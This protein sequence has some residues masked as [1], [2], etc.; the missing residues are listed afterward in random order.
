MPLTRSPAAQT[1][2]AIDQAI[3]ERL[4]EI[5]PQY[6]DRTTFINFQLDSSLTLGKPQ[7][8]SGHPQGGKVLPF[9]SLEEQPDKERAH[10]LHVESIN[11]PPAQAKPIDPALEAHSDLIRDF[12]R[13][14]K[15]S[16]GERA[17]SLLQTG[18]KA[19][20]AAYGDDVVR[21]QLELAINGKWQSITLANYERFKPQQKPWEQEPET[22]HPAFRDAREI[23]AEQEAKWKGIPSATGGRGVLEP[24]A[25]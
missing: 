9:S 22:K 18:L 16:K 2:I 23:I 6:M 1:R 4:D 14:K 17:W 19:I 12:W 11:H 15:G 13:T 8:A 7:P 10:A 20:Q 5:R 3:L 24:G 21:E 25:I